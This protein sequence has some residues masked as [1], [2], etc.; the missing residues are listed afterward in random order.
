MSVAVTSKGSI[1]RKSK[2][3]FIQAFTLT[4]WLLKCGI[5]DRN[6][7]TTVQTIHVNTH[8]YMVYSLI[9]LPLIGQRE[10][11][12]LSES[13]FTD[14]IYTKP[15]TFVFAQ[16]LG[17][18]GEPNVRE[19]EAK[20]WSNFIRK[21]LWNE[22][23]KCTKNCNTSAHDVMNWEIKS[24]AL[25]CEGTINLCLLTNADVHVIFTPH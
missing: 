19:I 8:T 18:P 24:F 1:S 20:N 10:I 23:Q 3:A 22:C 14:I 5:H 12:I 11:K 7:L 13:V 2:L 16:G 21:L 25:S 4:K 17:V 6:S 15:P 9:Q